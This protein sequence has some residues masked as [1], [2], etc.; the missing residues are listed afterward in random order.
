MPAGVPEDRP[1]APRVAL[2][3]NAA[4]VSHWQ[5]VQRGI[6]AQAALLGWRL[7]FDPDASG[8][9]LLARYLRWPCDGLIAAISTPVEMR[10]ARE[11]HVPVVNISDVVDR[12][13]VPLVT[14]DNEA[15]GQLAAEHLLGQGYARFAFYGLDSLGYSRKRQRGF[16]ETLRLQGFDCDSLESPHWVG[17]TAGD[18]EGISLASNHDIIL[19]RWLSRFGDSTGLFAVS[20]ARA[21]MVISACSRLGIDV[22]GR[23]GV[24]GVGNFR[25][26]CDLAEPPLSSVRH[27]GH[28]VGAEACRLLAAMMAGEEPAADG[29]TRMVAPIDVAARASTG[30]G[31]AESAV[32]PRALTFIRDHIAERFDIDD[33]VRHLHISRRKLE[34]AFRQSFGEPP[35]ARLLRMRAEAAAAA[36]EARPDLPLS[37]AAR[38][39][40]FRD[41]RHLRRTLKQLGMKPFED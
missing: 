40:G 2:A 35:H 21:A 37:E 29:R 27:N 28:E 23:L 6:T 12:H 22:P 33:L 11:A 5:E 30:S 15:I 38:A 13:D 14:F 3:F 4:G 1:A 34:R 36:L 8:S 19:E 32:V 16:V 17:R 24:L 20:D 9:G 39:A 41:A 10:L 7:V 26:L 18:D 25:D 31:R